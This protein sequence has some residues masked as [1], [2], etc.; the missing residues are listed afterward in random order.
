MIENTETALNVNLFKPWPGHRHLQ[1]VEPHPGWERWVESARW[2]NVTMTFIPNQ[3]HVFFPK[4]KSRRPWK[5]KCWTPN[6]PLKRLDET[7][8]PPAGPADGCWWVG[9]S[10]RTSVW[11][12]GGPRWRWSPPGARNGCAKWTWQGLKLRWPAENW[13]WP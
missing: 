2:S 12:V 8:A 10:P 6:L 3:P 1:Y 11:S 9:S 7:H 4:K 13:R 5:K